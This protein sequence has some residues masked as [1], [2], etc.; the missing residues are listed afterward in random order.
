MGGGEHRRGGDGA[1]G[2]V[3]GS[4]G[5]NRLMGRADISGQTITFGPVATT[6]MACAGTAMDQQRRLLDA[7]TSTRSCRIAG[8]ILTLHDGSGVELVRLARRP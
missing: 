5:C 3:G 4:G 6:R 8:T 7:L 1:D 2:A